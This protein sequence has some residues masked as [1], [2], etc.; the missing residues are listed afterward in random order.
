[1][2]SKILK[3]LTMG[4]A[5]IALMS[6]A[7]GP[8]ATAQNNAQQIEPRAG[9]WQTWLLKNGSELRPPAPPDKAA[10]EQELKD[11][12][13]LPKQ[14]DAKTLAQITYWD[15]GSPSYRWQDLALVSMGK[16]PALSSP[17]R[18][19]RMLALMN[20]AIADAMIA[21][22]DAKYAYNRPRPSQADAKIAV[23]V[24]VPNSPS[25][26][27]EHAVAAGAAS[28]VL[29]YIYPEDAK[30]F[31]ALAQQAGQS[32]VLAGVQYPS[33]VTAGLALGK[34]VAAKAIERAKAD[35]SDAKWTGSIPTGPGAWVGENPL[36]P[37]AGTWKPWVLKSGD[38]F[39][40]A[41]PPAFDSPEK[42]ADLAEIKA[43][44]RTFASNAKSMFWQT[45]DGIHVIWTNNVHQ[46]LFEYHLYQNPPRAAR[47]YA[48][49][50][51]TR[52]D[53]LIGCWDAKYAYWAIRPSQLD[54]A[55]VP[56]FPPPPH[57]SYPAAHGCLSTAAAQMLGY[58]FPNEAKFIMGKA[59]E[60]G[61]SRIWAGIHYR[62]DVVAGNKLGIQVAD[63]VIDRAKKDGS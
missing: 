42:L 54:K 48:L 15:A 59:D 20:T 29:S 2:K 25:Y 19:M 55:V 32:R 63:L 47:A 62:S 5:A 26:P 57:P 60:A 56:L 35:G 58:L 52:Y 33:D 16:F 6:L 31:E 1:M 53:A 45:A 4:S 11:L 12:Q 7:L 51:V 50:S 30:L 36:E 41:A 13:K 18:A 40:P 8:M 43:F 14:P 38:Q 23:A 39:R 24:A 22:W 9:K 44:T 3:N 61:Q 34:A 49:L 28:A 10:T 17:P 37:L 46:R 27:S 21:A